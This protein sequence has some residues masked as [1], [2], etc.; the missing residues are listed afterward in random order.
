MPRKINSLFL[1]VLLLPS[2][3]SMGRY[4]KHRGMDFLDCIKANVGAGLGLAV[5]IK[6]TEYFAPGLGYMSF[7]G[8]MGWDDRNLNGIWQEAVVVNT[9]RA[10][11]E[12]VGAKED[13]RATSDLKDEQRLLRLSLASL[14]LAN[15]RWIRVP[16]DGRVEVEY[17]SLLN[18]ATIPSFVRVVDPSQVF[19]REGEV[20]R[21][22]HKSFWQKGWFEAGG[23]AVFFHARAGVNPFEIIDFVTGIFGL[24]LAG[25][26]R[27]VL[28]QSADMG[29]A[30]KKKH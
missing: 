4:F 29:S 17:F 11:W 7:T 24:D 13:E 9:P 21:R 27:V 25:D 30:A 19:L 15:E 18:F 2:C 28:S 16:K 8:N 14:L 5:D 10:V 20:P 6:A 3:A 22:R 1:L 26:D 23:T 12:V